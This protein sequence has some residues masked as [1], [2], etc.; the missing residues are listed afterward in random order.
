MVLPYGIDNSPGCKA[1]GQQR[2]IWMMGLEPFQY[3]IGLRM[4]NE[5]AAFQSDRGAMS[6]AF[7]LHDTFD[8]IK[9]QMLMS[10]LPDVAVLAP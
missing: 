7:A 6:D 9:R 8:V 3:L 1:V 5:L 2:V 4:Q 10:F